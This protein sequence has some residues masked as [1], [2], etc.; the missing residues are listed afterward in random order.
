MLTSF[1]IDHRVLCMEILLNHTAKELYA[2][3]VLYG[4]YRLMKRWL[5][6]AEEE[7]NTSELVFLLRVCRC[8][9]FDSAAIKV[10][11]IGKA[12]KRL[13]KYT[14]ASGDGEA[15][16]RE[17][18]ALMADWKEKAVLEKKQES[19]Q[20]PPPTTSVVQQ[21][22]ST[23]A[24]SAASRP[25][26]VKD[27]VKVK[28][29]KP[30]PSVSAQAPAPAPAPTAQQPIIVP[31]KPAASLPALL[32]F[33]ANPAV[34]P[35]PA[36]ERK[37]LD[38]VEG[39][40]K[41]LA[42]KAQAKVVAEEV[43]MEVDV[44]PKVVLQPLTKGGTKRTKD[45]AKLSV[46][47]ADESGG[48]LREVHSI[49][50]DKIKSSV[51]SYK[52]HKDLVRKEKQLEK[53]SFSSKAEEAMQ[54]SVPFVLPGPWALPIGILDNIGVLDSKDREK[55]SRRLAHVLEVRYLDESLIPD[56]PDV[57]PACVNSSSDDVVEALWL[58]PEEEAELRAAQMKYGKPLPP[59]APSSSKGA[60]QQMPQQQMMF[61]MSKEDE[62]NMMVSGLP[63]S[64]QML[65]PLTLQGVLQEPLIL[66]SLLRPDGS[67]DETR[68]SLLQTCPSVDDYRQVLFGSL[69]SG[70]GMGMGMMGGGHGN[71]Y[72]NMPVYNGSGGYNA[73]FD[74]QQQHFHQQ[75]LQHQQL[76]Q[77]PFAGQYAAAQNLPMGWEHSQGHGSRFEPPGAPNAWNTVSSMNSRQPHMPMGGGGM[78]LGGPPPAPSLGVP[79]PKRFNTTKAG[80][81]CRFFN[82]PR[83]CGNGDK[84]PFGHFLDS[85]A[86]SGSAG[87][88]G[89]GMPMGGG[90]GM[91]MRS[92]PGMGPG[93]GRGGARRR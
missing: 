21:D 70:M 87:P 42:L 58:S 24:P 44:A 23:A 53:D 34:P 48:L 91:G 69:T 38:M 54:A 37:S 59:S 22:V 75:Q 30:Q 43:P 64:I 14:T 56:D 27:E 41:L 39:A 63:I 36:R 81:A 32:P 85:S 55:Q 51:A 28:K 13:Q 60:Q 78:G 26:K 68:L 72:G 79:P 33:L 9:P 2:E 71:G 52:S 76:P 6:E 67:V 16:Q 80:T 89:T 31:I 11:E 12:I 83:G 25:V 29:E 19:V 88:M 5:H 90:P 73:G 65:D 74:Q 45:R 8:L 35:K 49:E 57:D 3:F 62:Y 18:Q 20:Q 15:L 10:A 92:G 47:W 77:Q 84:C 82:T 46:Q 17:V 61:D 40:R 66:Q 7:G 86:G 4:G 50:V 93:P 1:Q